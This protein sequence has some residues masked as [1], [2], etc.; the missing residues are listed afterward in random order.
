VTMHADS[1]KAHVS[2]GSGSY[3]ECECFEACCISTAFVQTLLFIGSIRN[4]DKQRQPIGVDSYHFDL[5]GECIWSTRTRS[6]C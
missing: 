3:L 6:L 4:L 5:E 2:S 1:F